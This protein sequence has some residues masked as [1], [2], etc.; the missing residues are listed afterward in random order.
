MQRR[1]QVDV[2]KKL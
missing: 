1:E 2:I